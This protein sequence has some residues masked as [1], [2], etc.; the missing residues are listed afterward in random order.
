MKLRSIVIAAAMAVCG[1]AI[2][3]TDDHTPK[4]GGI[5]VEGK[6]LDFEIVAKADLIQVYVQEHGKK[7]SLE[8]AKGKLTLLSATG[9]SDADLLPVG[10]R[11]EAK[12]SFQISK[13]IKGVVSVTLSG[14]PAATARFE[15]N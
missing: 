15:L 1:A 10:D 12:G 6:A 4:H 5:V 3:E 9:K 13:G 7:V 11:M 14:K 8:G 2:A